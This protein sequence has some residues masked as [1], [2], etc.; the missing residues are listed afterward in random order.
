MG[1]ITQGIPFAQ[2]SDV[3]A[4]VQQEKGDGFPVAHQVLIFQGKVCLV[5]DLPGRMSAIS[6]MQILNVRRAAT[7]S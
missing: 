1:T 7:R 2:V 4:K 3:K 6:D 5:R